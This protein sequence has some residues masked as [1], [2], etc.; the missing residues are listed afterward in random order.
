MSSVEK[1]LFPH[2]SILF[3]YLLLKT[4]QNSSIIL[5]RGV[6]LG[7][8]MNSI[9][10]APRSCSFC[11][12]ILAQWIDALSRSKTFN[13]AVSWIWFYNRSNRFKTSFAFI[14]PYLIRCAIS[15]SSLT[16]PARDTISDH[17]SFLLPKNA[18]SLSFPQ[19]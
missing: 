19:Q 8:N 1:S 17:D 12:T 16:T 3:L 6:Y 11:F 2:Q 18:H 13:P 10:N 14:G 9:L 7:M 15:P 4:L 5:K